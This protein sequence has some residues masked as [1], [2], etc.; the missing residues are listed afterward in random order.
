ML[1]SD[2]EVS[3]VEGLTGALTALK[4]EDSTLG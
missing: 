3:A 2:D 1:D 4:P